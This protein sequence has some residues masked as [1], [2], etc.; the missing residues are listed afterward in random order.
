MFQKQISLSKNSRVWLSGSA[1]YNQHHHHHH[2]QPSLHRS[3]QTDH[4][5]KINASN[6]SSQPISGE[7]KDCLNCN[8]VLSLSSNKIRND[9]ILDQSIIDAFQDIVTLLEDQLKPLVLAELSVLV[10][11]FYKPETL[12]PN[13]SNA[14]KICSNGGFIFK[15]IKHTERLMEE[16][17]EKLCIKILQTLK[18]MMQIDSNFDTNSEELRRNLLNRFLMQNATAKMK[19]RNVLPH[20]SSTTSSSSSTSS[21]IIFDPKLDGYQKEPDESE[22]LLIDSNHNHIDRLDDILYDDSSLTSS[23]SVSSKSNSRTK[24]HQCFESNRTSIQWRCRQ[25]FPKRTKSMN[26]FVE[27]LR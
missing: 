1:S 25:Q 10:D 5:K 19:I 24:S 2:R 21:S 11:I 16:N 4:L 6:G 12:F 9:R 14:K 20:Q 27:D 22:S 23:F 13:G 17:D 7:H 15:L 8:T 3:S 26:S 18:E